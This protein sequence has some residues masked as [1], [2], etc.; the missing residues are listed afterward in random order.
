LQLTSIWAE[1]NLSPVVTHIKTS[2]FLHSNK[3][4]VSLLQVQLTEGEN[5]CN[6]RKK[7]RD[8]PTDNSGW[9]QN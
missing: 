9:L 5:Q 1:I 6:I 3:D 8:I 7:Q 2:G 4:R